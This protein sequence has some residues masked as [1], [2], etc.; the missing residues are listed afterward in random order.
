MRRFDLLL[1]RRFPF[2]LLRVSHRSGL[3][4]LV[5]PQIWPRPRPLAAPLRLAERPADKRAERSAGRSDRSPAGVS[6]GRSDR[7]ADVPV[8][9]SDRWVGESVDRWVGESVDRWADESAADAP[10]D[11]PAVESELRLQA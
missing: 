1:H 8:G 11:R 7:S 9:R 3:L 4:W 5:N 10:A 6:A 2:R